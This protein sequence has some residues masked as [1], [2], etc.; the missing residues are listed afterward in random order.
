MI[1]LYNMNETAFTDNGICVLDPSVC[2]VSE[3]A[4]GSYELYMEHP[5]DENGK[6]EM[7]MENMLIKAPVP[8]T[9]IPQ[10]TLPETTIYTVSTVATFW[11]QMPVR[12]HKKSEQD[13][14]AVVRDA[15]ATYEWGSYKNYNDGDYVSYNGSIYKAGKDIKGAASP[16]AQDGWVFMGTVS[17]DTAED[18][19]YTP[20]ETYREPLVLG[21]MVR[22][23]ASVSDTVIQIRDPLGRVGYYNLSNLTE[24]S[25]GAETLPE[26]V[27]DEQVFRVY[28]LESEEETNV[29]KVYARHISY[30]FTGNTLLDC[31]L[32]DTKVQD[33]IAVVQGNLMILDDRQIACEF[34]GDKITKDWSYKN[35]I[36]ALLDPDDGLVPTLRA[37]LIR[38]NRDF[39]ILKN[40]NPRIGPTL[41]YGVNLQGVTWN[42]NVET[43]ITRVVPR[44]SDKADGYVYLEHGGTWDSQG[45]WQQSNDIYVESSIASQFPY[46]RIE[47]MDVGYAIGDKYTPAGSSSEKEWT[48]VTAREDML[49]KAKERFTK[50]HCDGMEITLDVEFTLLG[51]TEQYKQYKGLQRVNL[52][53]QLPIKSRAFDASAQVISYEYN[54]LT[55]RY[56]SVSVGEVDRFAKRIPGYRVVTGSI[57]YSKLS[58]D[59]ISRIRTMGSPSGSSTGSGSGSAPSSGYDVS[60][61][62]DVNTKDVAGIVP[63]GGTN[64]GKVWK[65]DANGNP[66]WRDE[67]WKANS[68]SSEGYVASGSGHANK[69]WATDANGNPGWRDLSDLT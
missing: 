21:Q 51:D 50:D 60:T 31:K 26:Q 34:D 46:P 43:V 4:G 61:T 14:T 6:Y 23:I 20:G 19:E 28:S 39:Y 25:T 27:I 13:K 69:V 52:Y 12:R 22:K 2:N 56:N 64:Y 36:Y 24:Q 44:C 1:C 48:L 67:T 55:G 65:T 8:H 58:P 15:S 40:N 18:S 53:D 5:F 42:R 54:C 38:N 49:K 37:K 66:A 17:G 63:K 35:P 47:V 59:L 29:L 10:I 62:V 57:T 68:S 9:V 3:E 33:A 32:E 45:A 30:D 7:I 11:K 41:E 16:S